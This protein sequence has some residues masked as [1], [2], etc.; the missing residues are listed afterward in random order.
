MISLILGMIDLYFLYILLIM[1]GDL[2][3]NLLSKQEATM[4]RFNTKVLVY[5]CD[6]WLQ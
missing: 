3:L 6:L 5:F 4:P 2:N 1:L